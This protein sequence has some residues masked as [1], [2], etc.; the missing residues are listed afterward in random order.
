MKNKIFG[1]QTEMI[2]QVAEKLEEIKNGKER[3][4]SELYDLTAAYVILMIHNSKVA[5]DD[6][7]DLLQEIYCSV[8]TSVANLQHCQAG[9]AWMKRIANNK[10]VDYCRRKY[11]EEK[12]LV[13][14]VERGKDEENDEWEFENDV[15][16]MPE[17][18]V[19]SKETQRMV[20][21]ILRN[22][23]KNQYHILWAFYFNNM[24]INEI[25]KMMEMNE[26][27]VK[28]NLRRAKLS[29]KKQVEQLQNQTGVLLRSVPIGFALYLLFSKEESTYAAVM[30]GRE[31]VASAI[32]KTKM[33]VSAVKAE[34][35]VH[36]PHSVAV[37]RMSGRRA[38]PKLNKIGKLFAMGSIACAISFASGVVITCLYYSNQ[39]KNTESVES[40]INM[41]RDSQEKSE[42]RETYEEFATNLKTLKGEKIEVSISWQD[43]DQGE[44]YPTYFA[45][46]FSAGNFGYYIGDF[47]QDGEE[48]LFT[49]DT[50]NGYN[51]VASIY[52]WRDE[53]VSLADRKESGTIDLAANDLL[54]TWMICENGKYILQE[55]YSG[56]SAIS[57]GYSRSVRLWKYDDGKFV[58]VN[59][60]SY[61]GSS[62]E[63]EEGEEYLEQLEIICEILNVSTKDEEVFKYRPEFSKY[64]REKEVVAQ[65]VTKN[66]M[67]NT[68]ICEKY[69]QLLDG[70]IDRFKVA[71][72]EVK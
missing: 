21:E 18:V 12:H 51:V 23:P 67:S 45:E 43:M 28:T 63:G 61:V 3:A 16:E 44:R 9:M 42:P 38:Q 36:Q 34:N 56:F 69:E 15:F 50:D 54:D 71:E 11:K 70:D 37:K 33:P 31:V 58:E 4:F 20:R 27:T 32:G 39:Q 40:L 64:L 13:F 65:I 22:L 48:E 24:K 8:Y 68:E 2:N 49:V 57:D 30:I 53:Q 17:D 62:I 26:S 55:Y 46:A 47:D 29:F 72:G 5:E 41:E 35:V 60:C 66:I 59:T 10:I 19:D 1:D 14:D 6:Q 7:E 52:E 25:A